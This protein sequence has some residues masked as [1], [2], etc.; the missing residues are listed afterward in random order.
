MTCKEAAAVIGCSPQQVRT[1]IRKGKI[2]AHR[3]VCPANQYG[4]RYTVTLA[5]AERYRDAPQ[6]RGWPRGQGYDLV[7]VE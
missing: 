7:D 6:T 1:L 2:K 4:Y 3:I 5:E